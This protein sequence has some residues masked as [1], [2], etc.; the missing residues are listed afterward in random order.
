MNPSTPN[1]TAAASGAVGALPPRDP[2]VSPAPLPGALSLGLR[3][4]RIEI[5]QL[6][7]DKEAA[8]FTF[9]LPMLLMVVSGRCS[10]R[11]SHPASRSAS[12]S[13]PA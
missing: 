12:T 10:T 8:V 1:P 9:A 2:R 7:R 4:T 3:R 6:Y 11:R 5:K 13:Q